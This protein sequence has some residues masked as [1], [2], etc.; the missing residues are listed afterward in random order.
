VRESGGRQS[1]MDASQPGAARAPEVRLER[2]TKRFGPTLA[3]DAASVRFEPGTI[4][5]LVGENG[6]GKSTLMRILYG[7]L[8]PDSGRILIDGIEVPIASPAHALARGIGMIHQHFMLVPAMTV[9]ENIALGAEGMRGL[10]PIPRGKLARGLSALFG[11]YGFDIDPQAR[12]DSLGVG[13]RQRV[14]I[15]RLL[16]RGAR[17]LICDEPTAVL[18]PPEV[19]AFLAI[20]RRFRDEGRTV[21][22][23][24]HKLAEVLEVADRVSVLR[25]G[26]VVGEMVRAELDRDALVRMI[27]GEGAPAEAPVAAPVPIRAAPSLLA[28]RAENRGEGP[29]L[30]ARDLTVRGEGGRALLE[31]VTCELCPGEILGVAGVSGNGQGELSAVLAGRMRFDEG[32]LR[33]GGCHYAAGELPEPWQRPALIPEDR[34]SQGLIGE[35]RLW[36]NLLLG[37]TE[38]APFLRRGWYAHRAARAWARPQ[39][40]RFRVTPGDETLAADAL[41]GGNQQ[42]LLCARELLRGRGLLVANQPTRGID[43]TSTAFVHAT[44][45]DFRAAGGSVVLISAD[46]DEILALSDRVAVIYRGHLGPASPRAGLDLEAVG[47][48]MVGIAPF[49]AAR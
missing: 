19:R 47:R 3:N 29:V 44:L 24:T 34:T 40:K 15:G 16:F 32:T 28:A 6:A 21:V 43:I 41:S 10:K 23:I 31:R 25:G 12:V 18:A 11:Q 22:F 17:L 46:L 39:L 5:A 30:E 36:E 42:K 8:H 48:A 35:F 27:M 4:H 14:E 37:R 9:L 13:E 49:Q 45:R 38:E 33:L 1:S 7:L 2:I 26:R 20:L